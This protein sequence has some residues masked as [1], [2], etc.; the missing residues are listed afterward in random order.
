[1][2][3]SGHVARLACSM[4]ALALKLIGK[5]SPAWTVSFSSIGHHWLVIYWL[6]LLLV[7]HALEASVHASMT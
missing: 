5:A 6:P 1:M 7:Q 4:T 2:H 3:A